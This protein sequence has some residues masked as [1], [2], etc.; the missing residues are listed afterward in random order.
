MKRILIVKNRAL[1]D[2]IIG[3]STIQYIKALL[4]HAH[5]TYALPNWIMPLY[6]NLDTSADKYF[7]LKFNNIIDWV[8]LFFTLFFSGDKFDLIYELHCSGSSYKFFKLYSFFTRTNYHFNNHHITKNS[9]PRPS[10][11]R[12][13]EGV[14]RFLNENIYKGNLKYPNYLEYE[15]RILLKSKTKQNKKVKEKEEKIIVLGIVASRLSK[16]WPL[17]YFKKLINLITDNDANIRFIIPIS[18]T[19]PIDIEVEKLFNQENNYKIKK[20]QNIQFIKKELDELPLYLEKAY[21]YIGNDTGLKHL[22]VAMGLK[23]FTFFGPDEPGEWH[24]Y[25]VEIH[26][27]FFIENKK[28]PCRT[29]NGH[30]CGISECVSCNCLRLISVELV[31]DVVKKYL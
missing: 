9:N 6:F 27:C 8:K 2:S 28:L 29:K 16:V 15:P 25:N 30:F 13:L 21:L 1:G 26:H 23:T 20:S 7:S 19:Y 11:E 12:D 17:E 14:W 31:F 24:P 3:L 4:P 18:P 5:I 22:S 10:I